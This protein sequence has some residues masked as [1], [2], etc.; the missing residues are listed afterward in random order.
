MNNI[1]EIRQLSTHFGEQLIHENLDLDIQQ[2]EVLALIGGSGTGKST[3]LREMILLETPVSGSIRILDH[4]ILNLDDPLWLRRHCGVMFQNGALFGSLTVAENIALPLQEH[5]KLSDKLIAEIVALKIELVK[6]PKQA[7]QLYPNQ[8]SGG[9][10]KRAALARALA[11]DPQILFLDEPTAGLDP[12]GAADLDNLIVDLK[13]LLGLTIVIVTHDL[14][15]L[16]QV[17]DRIAVLADKQVIA[18]QP[19]DELLEFGHEWVQS[20]FHG[21]RGERLISS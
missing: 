3:L 11:L 10:V 8:L 1:I 18:V 17:T 19:L 4:D 15:S 13:Q 7:G 9:M 20:Y 21:V 5:T 6:L 12:I 14:D 16:K 2:G